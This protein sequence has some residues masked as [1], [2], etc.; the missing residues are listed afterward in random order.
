MKK[1]LLSIFSVCLLVVG[2]QAQSAKD[3][4]KQ[5]TEA[6]G[7][8][9]KQ[10]TARLL[11]PEAPL[12]N[13]M[14]AV[15]ALNMFAQALEISEK[16]GDIKKAISGIADTE[17]HLANF[18]AG[19]YQ[20]EDYAGS[21]ANFDA[22][23]KAHH[24]LKA[25]K[26][27]SRLDEEGLLAEQELFAGITA[28][29]SENYEGAMPYYQKLYENGTEEATVYEGLYTMTLAKDPAAA[30]EILTAGREKFPDNTSLLFTEINQYLNEGRLAELIG[31]LEAARAA[32]PNNLSVITTLGNVFD[33]LHVKATEDGDEAKA[34]EY[35]QSAL[36][37]YKEVLD[38]DETNFDAWYSSGALYY[39]KAANL[40]PQINE[41][42]ND[43][44]AEGTKK[45]EALKSKMD[46]TFKTSLPYFE[47]AEALKAG[48]RNTIIALKEIY[49]R[50]NQ[51][52]KVT[53]Y[54]TKLDAIAPQE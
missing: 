21:F 20:S 28:F 19:L 22:S 41:L 40:A 47:K 16:K 33:Q 54:Q 35:F 42:A 17:T 31:K 25:N 39:N 11:N 6:I 14:A 12:D 36:G 27:K 29:Y 5:A 1:I 45:Y 53:E 37:V 43:F 46:D 18:G 9:D 34:E 49:A 7:S 2:L 48:D 24:L 52:D 8:A 4:I 44:S 13:P 38:K 23:I 10:F 32:E 3:L 15:E 30:Q 50:Q 26:Q 51:F